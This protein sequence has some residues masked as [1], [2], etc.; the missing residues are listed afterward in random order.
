MASQTKE[1]ANKDRGQQRKAASTGSAKG[2]GESKSKK[3]YRRSEIMNLMQNDPK[4]YQQLADELLIAYE[5]GRV[6]A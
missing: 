5:E 4:R 3:I 6:R 2:T 1:I